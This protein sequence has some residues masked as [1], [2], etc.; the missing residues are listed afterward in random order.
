MEMDDI[1]AHLRSGR[2]LLGKWQQL[3]IKPLWILLKYFS[4][5]S[6]SSKPTCPSGPLRARGFYR[7]PVFAWKSSTAHHGD[8]CDV[9]LVLVESFS[10]WSQAGT[11][12]GLHP[13]RGFFLL[14]L[15]VGSKSCPYTWWCWKV[16]FYSLPLGTSLM[17][18]MVKKKK[19]KKICQPCR[20]PQFKPWVRKIPWRR[21][22]KPTAVFLPGEFHGQKRLEGYN[23][24]GHR[25]RHDW[26]TNTLETSRTSR[27]PWK[28]PL[29]SPISCNQ[30]EFPEK[31]G[32]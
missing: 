3:A 15:I 4:P 23:P 6:L 9:C 1:A 18:Q 20:R 13:P 12:A 29:L 28:T 24:W 25:V 30:C 2:L 26:V 14:W 5:S 21:E 32:G 22:W 27:L 11:R 10:H 19:K 16:M 17:A 7:L 31:V 8:A